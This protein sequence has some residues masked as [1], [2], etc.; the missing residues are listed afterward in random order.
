MEARELRYV[1][2]VAEERHFGRAA[3][4]LSVATPALSRSVARTEAELGVALFARQ[5]S[6][7]ALTDAGVALV[8]RVRHAIASLDDALAAAREAGQV[9][10]IGTL[11]VGVSTALRHGLAT[12]VFER[13][14][15]IC[16]GVRV[17]RRDELGGPLINELRAR[18][19]DAALTFCP[20]RRDDVVYEPIRDA[21]LVALVCASHPL[22]ARSSA[23]LSEL[24]NEAFLVPSRAADPG[25][26]GRLTELFE[27]SGFRGR[28]AGE[29]ID[30]D[31]DLTAVRGDRG[32]LLTSRFAVA[33]TPEGVALLHLSP[34][35]ALPIELAYRR[36]RPSPALARFVDAVR[37][38]RAHRRRR[39]S[40]RARARSKPRWRPGTPVG[41]GGRQRP[42]V[43]VAS[44]L[45][46]DEPP[47]PP[48]AP[49][50]PTRLASSSPAQH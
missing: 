20:V 33:N 34:P 27:S 31:E 35:I 41:R 3:A 22:A 7:V 6:G 2:A 18:Q 25:I 49:G 24:R 40:R 16:P 26:R 44:A 21:E 29:D 13:L 46:A 47:A 14:G 5:A 19:I 15:E 48:P 42:R 1:L 10:L 11:A 30:F 8:E 38:G 43:A 45:P 23:S 36:E 28:W 37:E 50:A 32:I 4:Q 39:R 12:A 9:E 17:A